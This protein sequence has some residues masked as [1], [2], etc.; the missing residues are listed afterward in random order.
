M[1][2]LTQEQ[3]LAIEQLAARW[4]EAANAHDVE[5]YGGLHDR[6]RNATR[7]SIGAKMVHFIIGDSSAFMVDIATGIIYGNKGWLK[8]DRNKIVGNAYDPNFDA[9]ALVRD[10]F[11][12]GH[13]ENNAD[14]SLR[15]PIVRR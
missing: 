1:A 10:H 9:K 8:V 12:Y 3:S 7:F 14:G 11:R 2:K 4:Q 13:F 6:P 5:F 15:Q